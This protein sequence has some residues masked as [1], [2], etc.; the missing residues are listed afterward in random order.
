[1]SNKSNKSNSVQADLQDLTL[2]KFKTIWLP[3][4]TETESAPTLLTEV[5]SF[6]DLLIV[7]RTPQKFY[8]FWALTSEYVHKSELSAVLFFS[9]FF[10]PL[11]TSSEA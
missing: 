2:E 9:R 1:M 4:L 6:F 10:P 5:P 11:G 7:Q 3:D 8:I